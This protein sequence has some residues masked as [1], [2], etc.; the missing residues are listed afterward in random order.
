MHS[1]RK[2]KKVSQAEAEIKNSGH[3]PA[4]RSSTDGKGC[5]NV[6]LRSTNVGSGVLFF[7]LAEA[8]KQEL[9]KL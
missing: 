5:I 6:S 7:K 8:A 4:S 3:F 1:A 2:F 9:K